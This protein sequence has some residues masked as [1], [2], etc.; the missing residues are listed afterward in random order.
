VFDGRL[1]LLKEFRHSAV[2]LYSFQLRTAI[3]SLG[4]RIGNW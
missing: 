2:A 3:M 4:M 1:A